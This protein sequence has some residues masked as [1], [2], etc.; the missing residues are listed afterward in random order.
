MA[1]PVDDGADRC[2]AVAE[3]RI[4]AATAASAAHSAARA[5]ALFDQ[6]YVRCPAA[7]ADAHLLGA[8]SAA[9][10]NGRYQHANLTQQQQH[11][12]G[13]SIN[14]LS[15]AGMPEPPDAL[16]AVSNGNSSGGAGG[17]ARD[18][19]A[20]GRGTS[21]GGNADDARGGAAGGGGDAPQGP[22]LRVDASTAGVSPLLQ[23]GHHRTSQQEVR[24]GQTPPPGAPGG[25]PEAAD[26]AYRSGGAA[27]RCGDVRAAL[28][29]FRTAAAA[30]PPG[31]PFRSARVKIDRAIS[32]CENKLAEAPV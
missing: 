7:A 18:A 6:D 13:A 4:A 12:M 29:L 16:R 22:P 8:S 23:P 11:N 32:A 15:E 3:A 5:G 1:L 19:S 26:A 28:S 27:L 20:G 24:R 14:D 2:L 9:G 21:S 30:C 31:A 10:A 17:H 25:D